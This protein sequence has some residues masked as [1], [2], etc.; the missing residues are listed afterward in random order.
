MLTSARTS[1]AASSSPDERQAQELAA[2]MKF[3]YT[4]RTKEALVFSAGS[5]GPDRDSPKF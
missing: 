4:L 2:G 5:Q 1:P 3:G